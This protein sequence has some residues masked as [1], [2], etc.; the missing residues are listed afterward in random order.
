MPSH[1]RKTVYP[2]LPVENPMKRNEKMYFDLLAKE[3]KG[4]RSWTIVS[5]VQLVVIVV[6]TSFIGYAVNLPKK[7]PVV[8][9]VLHWGE[10]KYVGDVSTYSHE[11]MN[12][13]EASFVYQV[14]TFIQHLRTLPADAEVLTKNINM[15][16]N[17]ITPNAE[18]KMTPDIRSDNPFGFIGKKKRS[19]IIESTIRVSGNTWQV[20]YIEM[21]SG[22]E[23]GSKR[24]RALV[25]TTRKTPPKKAEKLNPLG[26]YIEDYNITE[27]SLVKGVR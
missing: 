10:A 13:P 19:V 6:L 22:S 16:F 5:L 23:T 15:L 24:Y 7:I 11:T 25:T 14:E 9:T 21:L 4:K 3:S 1:H 20:D 18:K 2:D 26:I 8:I 17:M 27:I 12:I